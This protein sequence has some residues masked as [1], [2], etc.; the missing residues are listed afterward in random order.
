MFSLLT[1]Y[2]YQHKKIVFPGI[3]SFNLEPVNAAANFENVHA[4]GW[5]VAFTE[6]KNAV[7]ADNPDDFYQYLSARETISLGDSKQQFEEFS[8]NLL[9]KLNDNE[10]IEWDEIGS[11][12]KPDHRIVFSPK[13]AQPLFNGVNAQK[14]VRENADHQLLIGEKETSKSAVQAQ[15]PEEEESSGKYKKI[16]WIVLATVIII[17]AVFFLKNGCSVGSSGNKE[18]AVI[19]QPSDTYKIK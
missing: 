12:E 9:V 18:K 14:I 15:W 16:M 11:L 8:R 2:L 19:Q 7:A 4:P 3:G 13:N 1:A 10:V 17:G 6:N 5:S